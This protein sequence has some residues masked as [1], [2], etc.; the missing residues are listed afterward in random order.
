MYFVILLNSH[1]AHPA[2][3]R[4]Q[5][6]GYCISV[7]CVCVV[8]W[9]VILHH[10]APQPVKH[11]PCYPLDVNIIIWLPEI[12]IMPDAP[13]CILVMYKKVVNW[14]YLQLARWRLHRQRA[15][16]EQDVPSHVRLETEE[17]LSE[18]NARIAAI[19]LDP[20]WNMPQRES[21]RH[22]DTLAP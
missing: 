10:N 21:Q 7:I 19:P 3:I 15:R 14:M 13:S 18:I 22:S 17:R 20:S 11:R 16:Y 8:A 6:Y 2:I 4:L 12:V 9:F 1:S 5:S